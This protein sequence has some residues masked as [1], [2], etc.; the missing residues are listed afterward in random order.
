LPYAVVVA[1]F[2]AFVFYRALPYAVVV[3]RFGAFV[4]Y[5]ALPTLG[6]FC[7][8]L[9]CPIFSVVDCRLKT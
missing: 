9:L 5:R 7:W 1:R 4:F 6:L 3:A 8:F 2:G